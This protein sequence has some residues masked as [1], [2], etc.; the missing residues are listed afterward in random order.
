M[1]LLQLITLAERQGKDSSLLL[2]V[3]LQMVVAIELLD[4][5]DI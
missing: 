2:E 3:A 1:S 4:E 5:D